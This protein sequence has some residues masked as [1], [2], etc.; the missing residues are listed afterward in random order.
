MLAEAK[1][2]HRRGPSPG[3]RGPSS[4]A[5]SDGILGLTASLE[6]GR[7]PDQMEWRL[8]EV[9]GSK[10][11]AP[12]L[13]QPWRYEVESLWR[14]NAVGTTAIAIPI[15]ILTPGHTYRVRVRSRSRDGSTSRWS[16]PLEF[17]TRSGN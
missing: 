8:A 16:A 15:G 9:T 2:H 11:A 6:A 14:T 4:V 10:G 13:R 1:A 12:P 17:L 5:L 7:R 3:L